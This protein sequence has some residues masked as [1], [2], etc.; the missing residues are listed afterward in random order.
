MNNDI[1]FF[2]GEHM[3]ALPMYE[4]LEERILAQIPVVKIKV[5]KRPRSLL[6][7]SGDLLLCLSIP[8]AGRKTARK[9]G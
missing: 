8:A 2:F 3:D 6:R 5:A 4:K 1:L 9:S 7:A